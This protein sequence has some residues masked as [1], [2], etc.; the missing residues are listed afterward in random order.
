MKRADGKVDGLGLACLG[1]SIIL[2]VVAQLV[3]KFGTLGIGPCVDRS[4]SS[5]VVDIMVNLPVAL[6]VG[7]HALDIL[8]W[9]L[10]LSRLELSFAYP[11][12]SLQYV[13]I[14]AG[15][16]LFLNEQIGP[17]RLVGLAVICS[18]VVVMSFDRV[19]S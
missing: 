10:A 8:F 5:C 4:L 1:A 6:G 3:L 2:A 19:K 14:F 9:F 12:S 11:V 16:W 13:L 17:L 15:A 7:L 18:G